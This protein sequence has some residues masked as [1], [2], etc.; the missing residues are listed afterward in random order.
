MQNNN[1]KRTMDMVTK[2]INPYN[3]ILQTE[4][5]LRKMNAGVI[6]LTFASGVHLLLDFGKERKYELSCG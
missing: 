3:P 2:Q 4:I 5:T 6:T 1:N